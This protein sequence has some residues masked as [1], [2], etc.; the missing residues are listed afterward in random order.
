MST[1]ANKEL[2]RRYIAELNRGNLTALDE[3][4]APDYRLNGEAIGREGGRQ[5]STA[6]RV[7]FPGLQTT[8]EDLVAES[9]SVVMRYTWQ[10]TNTGK[11]QGRPPTG[12]MVT[13]GGFSLCRIQDGQ[14]HEE[15]DLDDRL[16]AMQQ[17][18]LLPA[19]ES[20][21]GGSGSS[22]P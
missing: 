10:G 13:A 15:W 3:L 14:I 22:A 2:V 20:A 11:L 21:D 16:G 19:P 5:Y 18:G 8:I 1:E 12:R 6:I 17:L 9:D 7:T 4:L